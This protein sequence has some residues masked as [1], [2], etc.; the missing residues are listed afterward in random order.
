[1]Y[2]K[3]QTI[4]QKHQPKDLRPPDVY[5]K[6]TQERKLKKKL[7]R[8]IIN[9][10][11]IIIIVLID[12]CVISNTRHNTCKK[13]KYMSVLSNV[14]TRQGFPIFDFILHLLAAMKIW[15]TS[16]RNCVN[17]YSKFYFLSDIMM[18]LYYLFSYL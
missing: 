9:V 10:S 16:S 15:F 2:L 5:L 13:L 17:I 4:N 18:K 11:N 3:K 1:M 12:T 7:Y 8:I 6:M 14:L